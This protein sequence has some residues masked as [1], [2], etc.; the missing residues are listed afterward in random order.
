MPKQYIPAVQKGVEGFMA[1]G[2]LGYPV[3]D[4]AVTLTD[5]SYHPVDSSDMAFQK[6]AQKAMA[7]AMKQL[8]TAG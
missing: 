4:I 7:E 8:A 3:V 2:P 5:G 1:R 6:A